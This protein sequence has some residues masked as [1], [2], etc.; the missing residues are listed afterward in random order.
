MFSFLHCEVRVVGP[1]CG[2]EQPAVEAKA[3]AGVWRALAWEWGQAAEV[4]SE[5][6]LAW[7]GWGLGTVLGPGGCELS[8]FSVFQVS[9]EF[10]I[11]FNPTNPFCSGECQVHLHV[12]WVPARPG[13]LPGGRR[14]GVQ[15]SV[16]FSHPLSLTRAQSDR[17][18]RAGGWSQAVLDARQLLPFP[19]SVTLERSLH[20]SGPL[21]SHLPPPLL[22]GPGP[23]PPCTPYLRQGALAPKD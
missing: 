1:P 17:W 2:S 23:A 16:L 15:L 13:H 12:P 8:V 14:G 11:N 20:L 10:A 7:W 9:H 6:A 22:G 18:G 4:P 5:G 21:P 3:D 19:G